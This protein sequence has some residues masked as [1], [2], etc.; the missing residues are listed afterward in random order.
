MK[1]KTKII[2][3]VFL[4]VAAAFFYL[5]SADGK[6]LLQKNSGAE[7]TQVSLE[8][9]DGRTE[10]AVETAIEAAVESEPETGF[11]DIQKRELAQIISASMEENINAMMEDGRLPAAVGEYQKVYSGLVNINTAG[12]EELTKLN[13][14]GPAKAKAIVS[15]REEHGAF[16]TLD[17]LANVSGI[18]TGTV[19]KLRD[20]ATL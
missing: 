19:E 3:A 20:Q 2:A 1:S 5:R 6:E 14:I 4:V 9:E 17:E 16:T 18:S 12:E 15:Y 7:K 11:N 10:D 8:T 13:G